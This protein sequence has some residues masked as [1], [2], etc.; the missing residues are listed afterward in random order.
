[1]SEGQGTCSQEVVFGDIIISASI[2]T[3]Y[4]CRNILRRIVQCSEG[5]QGKH[6]SCLL[7]S[8][9]GS[10]LRVWGDHNPITCPTFCSITKS[11][12]SKKSPIIFRQAWRV[13]ATEVPFNPF[14][15]LTLDQKHEL[16]HLLQNVHSLRFATSLSVN[17]DV[18][19]ATFFLS[20]LHRAAA[21]RIRC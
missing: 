10:F 12:S 1:M 16:S 4:L 14:F 8:T 19:E 21:R 5:L 13:G 11:V 2:Q 20:A 17:A 15:M 7:K 6:L 3:F 9:H 18:P